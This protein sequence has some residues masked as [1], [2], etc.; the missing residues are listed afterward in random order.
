M[1]DF[2]LEKYLNCQD[3][4]SLEREIESQSTAL[5]EWSISGYSTISLQKSFFRK[6]VS[7]KASLLKD[8][9]YSNQS[10]RAFIILLH[11]VCCTLLLPSAAAVLYEIIRANNLL[12]GSR[13]EAA[14]MVL[15]SYG[16]ND[17]YVDAFLPICE[18]LHYAIQNEEDDE[19]PCIS[20][21]IRY[22]AKI[23][24]DLPCYVDAIR[25]KISEN[26]DAYPFLRA[27]PIQ[28]A[29]SID[30]FNSQ[31]AYEQILS[32][33]PSFLPQSNRVE[34]YAQPCASRIRREYESR[35][36]ACPKAFSAI[37]SLAFNMAEEFVEDA[38]T[39]FSTLGRGVRILSSEEQLLV[40]MRAYGL[41]HEAKL[42]SAMNYVPF[43][44]MGQEISVVDWG[45]GQAVATMVL[46]EYLQ[47]KFSHIRVRHVLLIE[48]SSKAL[49]TANLHV[50]HFDSNICIT[51]INKD[52]DSISA[53]DINMPSHSPIVHLFSNILD[54][55]H[56]NLSHLE[57]IIDSRFGALNYFIC[58]SPHI[59]EIKT[60]RLYSFENHFSHKAGYTHIFDVENPSGTWQRTWTR[61]IRVYKY[62]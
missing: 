5:Y 14:F 57:D 47:N 39:V 60:A 48:P 61:A 29:L 8:L 9:D 33:I 18:K 11:D 22:Y 17:E 40:Y 51:S 1:N 42:K 30:T 2:S 37:R 38:D 24:R 13:M 26:E 45:C 52:F 36:V 49:E 55:E 62:G 59:N 15:S 7:V 54:V 41:M 10:N 16:S 19:R 21:F 43:G 3:V 58:C 34:E 6:F 53:S 35:L 44:E 31:A 12:V 56:F 27:I 46:L 20:V 50:K 28:S 32:F 25:Q 23:V 4:G